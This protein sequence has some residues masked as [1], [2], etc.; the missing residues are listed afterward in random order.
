MLCVADPAGGG[1][2][3]VFVSDACCAALDC[4]AACCCCDTTSPD[5]ALRVTLLLATSAPAEGPRAGN[6]NPIA[7]MAA[8]TWQSINDTSPRWR[9]IRLFH[10]AYPPPKLPPRVRARKLH[11]QKH[12]CC[13][14]QHKPPQTYPRICTVTPAPPEIAITFA[15]TKFARTPVA[16]RLSPVVSAELMFAAPVGTAYCASTSLIAVCN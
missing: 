8:Y 10:A 5:A 9:P 15:R 14:S 1:F 4:P 2:V 7:R 11:A 6:I 16:T 13:E 3:P 12:R